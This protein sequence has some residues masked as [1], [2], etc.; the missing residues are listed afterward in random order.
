MMRILNY[1]FIFIQIMLRHFFRF[2]MEI[3]KSHAKFI[4]I[5]FL[6]LV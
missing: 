4:L 1:L 6:T 5:L 2:Q 3:K